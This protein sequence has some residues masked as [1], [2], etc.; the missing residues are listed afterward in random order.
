MAASP[1]CGP[2]S[3]DSL[4]AMADLSRDQLIDRWTKTHNRRPPKGVSRTLLERSAAYQV[5]VKAQGG[6]S[7]TT[8]RALR[9]VLNEGKQSKIHKDDCYC[10][11][12]PGTRYAAG[13]RVERSHAHR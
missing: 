1:E 11:T 5:Q 3:K 6:L 2:A 8:R 12:P 4:E 9:S 7:A 13:T 10:Q